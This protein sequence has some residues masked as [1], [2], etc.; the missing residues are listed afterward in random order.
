MN[1]TITGLVDTQAHLDEMI[2]RMEDMSDPFESI[3]GEISKS[4]GESFMQ[5]GR[6]AHWAARVSDAQGHFRHPDKLTHPILRKTRRLFQAAI[7]ASSEFFFRTWY[8]INTSILHYGVTVPYAKATHFGDGH[9]AARPFLHVQETDKLR[10]V[11]IILQYL[12]RR[13]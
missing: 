1:I 8:G 12:M 4:I 2:R 10:F 11:A 13:V 5:E 9:V 3:R 6:P 7:G